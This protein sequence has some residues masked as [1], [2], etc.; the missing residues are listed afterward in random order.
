VIPAPRA[1]GSE[2]VIPASKTPGRKKQQGQSVVSCHRPDRSVRA[3]TTG[4]RRPSLKL[5]IPEGIERSAFRCLIHRLLTPFK[6][7]V[8]LFE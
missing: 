7:K 3:V 5:A 4:N 1:P 6:G 8:A 2:F